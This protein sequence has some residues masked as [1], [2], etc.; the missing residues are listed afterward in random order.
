MF[1]MGIIKGFFIFE[2]YFIRGDFVYICYKLN[3]VIKYWL[4]GLYVKEII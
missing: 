2:G 3:L 4:K 1:V